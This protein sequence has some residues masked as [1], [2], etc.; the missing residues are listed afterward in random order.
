MRVQVYDPTDRARIVVSSLKFQTNSLAFPYGPQAGEA[1]RY[2]SQ[3]IQPPLHRQCPPQRLAPSL[4]ELN[5]NSILEA[6]LREAFWQN[7][8]E[9]MSA[10]QKSAF[11]NNLISEAFRNTKI[12]AKND[13]GGIYARAGGA[14]GNSN[15][16]DGGNS[17][18]QRRAEFAQQQ[19]ESAAQV[20]TAA[21]VV[22]T[23]SQ[24]GA[25]QN[26]DTEAKLKEE[27]DAQL[28]TAQE[29]IR[30][31]EE[32]IKKL[33]AATESQLSN[34]RQLEGDINSV[35]EECKKLQEVYL[36]KK[37]TLDLLPNAEENYRKLKALVDGSSD[38]LMG[39]G[40]QWEQTRVP[41]INKYRRRKQLLHERKQEVGLK[42][43]QIKVMREELRR[44]AQALKEKAKLHEQVRAIH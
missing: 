12:S 32:N 8:S 13:E 22:E 23:V 33:D 39:L 30:K 29:K 37:R 24:D 38:R 27:R 17:A 9:Q 10:A 25:V 7:G 28:A 26:D 18:F 31:L 4:F 20:V 2:Y 44:K 41:L 34:A 5:A 16:Y 14:G 11:L 19:S 43:E 42:V 15:P 36:V 3:T 35:V 6:Q 1:A 40:S 21:G